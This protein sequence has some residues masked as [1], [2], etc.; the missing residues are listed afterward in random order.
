MEH[1]MLSDNVYERKK[2]GDKARDCFASHYAPRCTTF[3]YAQAQCKQNEPLDTTNASGA[4]GAAPDMK[5]PLPP[6]A[7]SDDCKRAWRRLQRGLRELG[8]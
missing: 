4:A 3:S 1:D 6:C 2:K 8:M 5:Q 7:I